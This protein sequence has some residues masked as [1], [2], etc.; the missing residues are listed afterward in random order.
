MANKVYS[1]SS[2]TTWM[3]CPM[4]RALSREGWQPKMLAKKDWSALLGQGFAAG[5]GI[6]NNLR[7]EWERGG[8]QAPQRDAA[9][10]ADLIRACSDAAVKIVQQKTEDMLAAGLNAG[11]DDQG[12]QDKLEARIRKALASYITADPIPDS[13]RIVE[14]E[15]DFGEDYGNARADLVARDTNGGLVIVDYKSKLTLAAQYRNKTIQEYANSH[16]MFHYAWSGEE[17]YSEPISTYYIGLAV[18]EPR[19]AFDLIAF[20][21]SPESLGV[22]LQSARVVWGNIER[23]EAGQVVP[24]LSANHSDNF[25][26]CPYYKACFVHHYDPSLMAADYVNVGAR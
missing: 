20:P 2:T 14:A 24:W 13:W 1:P 25:G 18:L 23:E 21:V 11:D 8:A 6:Y 17:T 26:Q 3:R 12:Y 15:K 4:M 7:Q 19:W 10:R 16:Q 22:W 9:T 5:V